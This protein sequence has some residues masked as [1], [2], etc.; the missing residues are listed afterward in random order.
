MASPPK[1]QFNVYLPPDLVRAVKHRSI[2]EGT[3][4]SALVERALERYL[5][6]PPGTPADSPAVRAPD[7]LTDPEDRS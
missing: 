3:S 5:A 1:A 7:G 2:D 4:L 6:T